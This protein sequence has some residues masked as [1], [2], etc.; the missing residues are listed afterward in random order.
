[1]AV[2]ED[3]SRVVVPKPRGNKPE[4][5]MAPLVDIVFLLLIFFMVTTV[6]PENRGLLIEKP[7]SES[8]EPL[9]MQ[10]ITF[11]I[12]NKGDVFYQ[13]QP[14]TMDD[15]TRLVAE[16]LQGAPDSAVFLQVDKA[17]TTEVLIGV[18]DACKRAGADQ[19][20]IATNAL[21]H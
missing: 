20:G 18:M 12:D 15:V 14:I 1:M 11:T 19:V 21:T 17:A 8:S 3:A 9:V 2:Q 7:A 4:I 6:F 10:K 13:E 16:Q 5:T